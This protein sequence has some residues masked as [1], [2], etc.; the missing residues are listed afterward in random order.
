MSGLISVDDAIARIRENAPG[1]PDETVPLEHALGRVLSEPVLARLTQPPSAVSAMDGY[2]V[3]LDDVREAG[4][5]LRLVGEAP[6]G[7]PWTGTVGFGETV[8]IFTG[9]HVPNGADHIVIQEDVDRAGDTITCREASTMSRHIRAA[10]RDFVTGDILI[11]QGERIGAAEIAIAAAA[12][13]AEL[14]VRKRPVVALL[15]NGDE[16]RLPGSAVEPGQI[17][18]SNPL[19]LGA[20]VNAWGGEVVDLGIAGDSAASIKTHLEAAKEAD[21]IVPVGGA[22]VGDHDHMRQAFADLDFQPIFQKVAV[23]PGKP[24]WFSK[25]ASQRVLGLPGNPASAFV[26]AHLF[27]RPLMG[28]TNGLDTRPAQL[29]ADVPSNGPRESFLRAN[30]RIGETGMVTVA[31]LP[32]Q[33]SSLLRPFLTANA[34]IRRPANAPAL[35]IGALGEIVVIGAL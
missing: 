10:G 3:R 34:L 29:V 33:D 6:A 17:V 27:L 4:A 9:G 16:L 26:C 30:A 12:N 11:K 31:P 7:R 19:G 2:A 8:R 5:R 35:T 28:W 32:D 25:T 24:T 1:L 13:H 14:T 18:S 23:R 21:I 15:A 22:S 20:L